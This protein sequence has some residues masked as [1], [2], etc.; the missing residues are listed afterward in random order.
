[1]RFNLPI[2]VHSVVFYRAKFRRNIN[3]GPRPGLHILKAGRPPVPIVINRDGNHKPLFT[4]AN[5]YYT[6]TRIRF[7]TFRDKIYYVE[8]AIES[9]SSTLSEKR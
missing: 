8:K 3:S 1:M 4:Y 5:L 2:R 9:N 7:T 6:L